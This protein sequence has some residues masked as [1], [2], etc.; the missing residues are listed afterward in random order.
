MSGSCFLAIAPSIC[1]ATHT[2]TCKAKYCNTHVQPAFWP[3]PSP[4][5]FHTFT[6]KRFFH[7]FVPGYRTSTSRD[8]TT[9]LPSGTITTKTQILEEQV[10]AEETGGGGGGGGER[11]TVVVTRAPE[12]SGGKARGGKGHDSLGL[13]FNLELSEAER[14]QRAAVL[15]PFQVCV[16][17]CMRIV[18]LIFYLHIN[19]YVCEE[20]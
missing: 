19:T 2:A 13:S 17:M 14:A 3:S 5:A 8:D 6:R 9:P 1:A 11:D 7:L 16:Y 20:T 10:C 18:I 4:S 12:A 15:L